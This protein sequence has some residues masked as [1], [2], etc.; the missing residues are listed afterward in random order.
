[1]RN[2]IEDGMGCAGL[3]PTKAEASAEDAF[4]RERAA[5]ERLQEELVKLGYRNVELRN[6][7]DAVRGLLEPLQHQVM[8]SVMAIRAAV[9]ILRRL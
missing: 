6:A 2:E 7:L 8:P 4:M 9:D 5:Y 3:V 1:M